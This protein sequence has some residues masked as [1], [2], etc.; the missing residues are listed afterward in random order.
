VNHLRNISS[1]KQ[2]SFTRKTVCISPA[3]HS[4]QALYA[5]G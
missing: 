2:Y 4:V 3:P 5:A 1:G